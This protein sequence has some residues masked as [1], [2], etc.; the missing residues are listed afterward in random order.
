MK[1]LSFGM[2]CR[3]VISVF[4]AE[5]TTNNTSNL[6]QI[7][8]TFKFLQNI[9]VKDTDNFPNMPEFTPTVF[10]FFHVFRHF[11]FYLSDVLIIFFGS[12]GVKIISQHKPLA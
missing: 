5:M 6:L 10:A 2:I 9:E 1:I 3:T 4:F 8:I 7:S 12:N 11:Y